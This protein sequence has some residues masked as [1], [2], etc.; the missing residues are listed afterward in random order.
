LTIIFAP[1]KHRKM[2][3]LFS[4]NHFTPNKRS[5]NQKYLVNFKKLFARK[6]FS[7]YGRRS[8]PSRSS[9]RPSPKTGNHCWIPSSQISVVVGIWPML[10]FD[11]IVLNF[12][13][14]IQNLP[15]WLYLGQKG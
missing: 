2:P 5:I 11:N 12:D 6:S 10:N 3:K 15:E 13:Q 7:P 9:S 14:T 4:R 1:T 8:Q